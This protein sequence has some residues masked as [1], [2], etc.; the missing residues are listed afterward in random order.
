MQQKENDDSYKYNQQDTGEFE[1][2]KKVINNIP[3]HFGTLPGYDKSAIKRYIPLFGTIQMLLL[4][5][6]LVDQILFK[7]LFPSIE[8]KDGYFGYAIGAAVFACMT[9]VVGSL[10]QKSESL[11]TKVIGAILMNMAIGYFL[12][13][14]GIYIS[15]PLS[16]MLLYLCIVQ[17]ITTIVL[18]IRILAI[19]S[20]IK[21][22][23]IQFISLIISIIVLESFGYKSNILIYIL[24]AIFCFYNSLMWMEL[25]DTCS[26]KQEVLELAFESFANMYKIPQWI[27]PHDD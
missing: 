7:V 9:V 17:F 8:S 15:Y 13:A 10:L 27:P 22:M 2:D 12:Y 20:V 26:T 4:L 24:S 19:Y 16:V 6:L 25:G 5:L 3:K 18:Y 11:K 21:I 14:V 23:L 1:K